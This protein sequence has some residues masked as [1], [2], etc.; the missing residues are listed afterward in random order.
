[1][2]GRSTSWCGCFL[3]RETAGEYLPWPYA[4]TL[5]RLLVV[6]HAINIWVSVRARWTLEWAHGGNPLKKTEIR[7]LINLWYN[8]C[9]FVLLIFDK[10]S[11][12]V[13]GFFSGIDRSLGSVHFLGR[14]RGGLLVH[15]FRHRIDHPRYL[16]GFH[17]IFPSHLGLA[18]HMV[19]ACRSGLFLVYSLV[20]VEFGT[21]RP[22]VELWFCMDLPI[23]GLASDLDLSSLHRF[24]ATQSCL[25]HR[26]CC[27]T[28]CHSFFSVLARYSTISLNPKFRGCLFQPVIQIIFL[29]LSYNFF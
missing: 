10:R 1:M 17:S 26:F 8:H 28:F 11:L 7:S 3:V 16:C 22:R 18:L 4:I 19:S 5:R 21:S 15:C 6:F 14:S 23:L 24:G 13:F 29:S 25:V 20:T 12:A 27:V 2:E 9:L